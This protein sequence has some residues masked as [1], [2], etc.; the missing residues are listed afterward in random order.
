[1]QDNL[2]GCASKYVNVFLAEMGRKDENLMIW[3]LSSLDLSPIENLC[4]NL[5][6]WTHTEEQ[7]YATMTS[8]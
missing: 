1:M 2:R 7:H 5:K 4:G 8:L 6:H 3:A